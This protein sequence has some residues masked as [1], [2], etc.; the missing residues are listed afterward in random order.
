M[1]RARAFSSAGEKEPASDAWP[2]M[3]S[4]GRRHCVP[5][6]RSG[7]RVARWASRFACDVAGLVCGSVRVGG[8]MMTGSASSIEGKPSGIV[9]RR[10][11]RTRKADRGTR[12][13]TRGSNLALPTRHAAASTLM[14]R[15]RPSRLTSDAAAPIDTSARPPLRPKP[16]SRSSSNL[17]PASPPACRR[18]RPRA[19]VA[20]PRRGPGRWRR[21]AVR[22]PGAT[23]SRAAER[24]IF[25]RGRRG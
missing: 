20:P 12:N 25:L 22:P 2:S 18:G 7:L 10:T 23:P 13:P 6:P 16:P 24:T 17:S 1:I 15:S 4:S 21:R 8:P 11:E 14:M 5:V 9:D 19:D 3:D